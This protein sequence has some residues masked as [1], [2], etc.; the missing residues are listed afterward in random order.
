MNYNVR[1]AVMHRRWTACRIAS[2]V[3]G[4]VQKPSASVAPSHSPFVM[5]SQLLI[6]CVLGAR[7]AFITVVVYRG[8]FVLQ[9]ESTGGNPG[10]LPKT[11]SRS[12]NFK[13]SISLLSENT[14]RERFRMS[15]PHWHRLHI[16]LLL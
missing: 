6:L 15:E 8:S 3:E 7:G 12:Y 4:K 10:L 13:N 1:G 14:E 9:L 2:V 5:Y 16:N 11:H